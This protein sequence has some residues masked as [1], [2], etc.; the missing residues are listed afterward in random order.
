MDL[1]IF[2]KSLNN[3]IRLT[4][5][6]TL[7]DKEEVSFQELLIKTQVDETSLSRHLC[8]LRNHH[9]IE[10]RRQSCMS[11]YRLSPSLSPWMLRC[12]GFLPL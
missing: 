9:L 4:C 1:L 11:Y 7:I 5:I 6:G 10:M 12:L 8:V 3:E 2:H